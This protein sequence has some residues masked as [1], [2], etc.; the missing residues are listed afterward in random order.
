MECFMSHATYTAHHFGLQN[1]EAKV[2][3]AGVHISRCHGACGGSVTGIEPPMRQRRYDAELSTAS[4]HRHVQ[5]NGS[6]LAT[7]PSCSSQL[8]MAASNSHGKPTRSPPTSLLGRGAMFAAMF[9]AS[10]LVCR[11]VEGVRICMRLRIIMAH[12]L[13]RQPN[14]SAMLKSNLTGGMTRRSWMQFQAHFVTK[15]IECV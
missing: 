15:A 11:F 7:A 13:R 14:R 9:Q 12:Q 1:A 8:R 5:P 4:F 10:D 3:N 6:T 2:C